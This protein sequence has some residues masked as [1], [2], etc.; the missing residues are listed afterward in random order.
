MITVHRWNGSAHERR[1]I[2]GLPESAAAVAQDEF[3]WVDMSD[4]TPEEEAAV[5]ERFLPTHPL[6][7]EDITR[8]R[9]EADGRAHFPKVEEFPDYLFVIVNPLPAALVE[10]TERRGKRPDGTPPLSVSRLLRRHRP[11]LSAILTRHILITHSMEPLACIAKTR[12]YVERHRDS[13][14][15]RAGF[16]LPHRPRCDGGRIRTRR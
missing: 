13:A 3:I 2:E 5:F 11:Q 12:Q 9:R 1:G 14:K 4:T 6:T 7:L 15:P 10:L 16:R 8:M